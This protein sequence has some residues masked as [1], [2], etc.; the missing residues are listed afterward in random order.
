MISRSRTSV[1]AGLCVASALGVGS[2]GARA[3]DARISAAS[4]ERILFREM[5]SVFGA[6][7]YEQ[8]VREAPSSV[9]IVTADEIRKYGYRTVAEILG[10]VRGFFATNDRNY[11]Y[12]GVRGFNRPGDY[13]SRILMLLDGHRLNENVY[14]SALVGT[15]GII[16]VDLI[17]RIEIIRGPSASLYGN[18][19]FF[20]VVN[21]IT[22]RGRDLNGGE[23]AGSA[24][25]LSASQGRFSY[26]NRLESGLELLLSGTVFRSRGNRSLFYPEFNT[27]ANNFGV[28]RDADGDRGQSLFGKFRYGDF[29]LQSAFSTRGKTIP[30][31]SFGTVFND[32]RNETTDERAYIELQHRRDLGSNTDVS[33]RL[34]YD[35]YYYWGQYVL[36]YPPPTVNRDYAAGRWMGGEVLLRHRPTARHKLTFGLEFQNNTRQDQRNYDVASYLDDHRRSRTLGLFLQDEFAITENLLLNAGLRHDRYS[37]FAGTTNPRLGLIYRARSSTTL[38][39][40]Y[41]SAYRAPNAFELYYDDSGAS[42]KANPSLKPETI[43]TAELV[44]E[45]RI[46][47]QW[48]FTGSFYRYRIDKLISQTVDPADG[49]LFYSNLDRINAHGV[50]IGVDGRSERGLETRLSLAFQENRSATTGAILSNSP[51]SLAKLGLIVPLVPD[52]AWTALDLRYV[53]ARNTL[54]N[55]TAD[56]VL[57]ANLTFTGRSRSRGW[58]W[59]AGIYNLFNKNYQDPGGAEHRQDVIAQDRRSLRIKLEYSF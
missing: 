47:R 30:T 4:D 34:F 20:G 33:S 21:I 39:A 28:A 53:S 59:S 44:L 23:L 17:E 2:L 32:P 46:S 51:R 3:D 25:S 12:I 8:D 14:D 48:R 11:S 19:A 15:E 58:Q 31:A 16:D 10:G 57:L 18:N 13:N 29:S 40:L 41:G 24:G 5:P 45:E 22:R 1:V 36:D 9:S 6:S 56:P 38:K 7:K 27:P 37:A 50:E 35:S 43:K 52:R 54:A 55:R 42:A 49:L 26:G